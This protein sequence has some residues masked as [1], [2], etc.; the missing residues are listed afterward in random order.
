MHKTQIMWDF[1]SLTQQQTESKSGDKNLHVCQWDDQHMDCEMCVACLL[2]RFGQLKK[3]DGRAEYKDGIVQ[4]AKNGSCWEVLEYI[5]KILQGSDQQ[6]FS[7]YHL[8]AG[9]SSMRELNC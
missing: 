5:G 1:W 7:E 2:G 6:S 4:A 9:K 3:G 8:A